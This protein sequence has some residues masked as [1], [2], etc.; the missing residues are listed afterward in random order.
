MDRIIPFNR[1]ADNVKTRRC[2]ITFSARLLYLWWSVLF[3]N[4]IE[5]QYT[6]KITRHEGSKIP[7]MINLSPSSDSSEKDSGAKLNAASFN[8]TKQVIMQTH[9]GWG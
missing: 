2:G 3:A 7:H 8:M 6:P 5:E 1:N 4:Q 9:D